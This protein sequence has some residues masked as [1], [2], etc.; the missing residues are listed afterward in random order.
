MSERPKVLVREEIA[1]AGV[2]L[3]REK[4]DVDVDSDERS[5]VDHRR[6]RR[7]RHPLRDQAHR[8]PDQRGDESEGDRARGRRRR[9]RRRGCGHPP[10]DRGRER[11]RVEHRLGRRAHG[12]PA[13]RARAEHPAGAQ[14]A[15]RQP[16][17]AVEVGR[18]RA[19]R[20][21]ARRARLRPDRPAGRAPRARDADA[22]R[23]LR[24]VR[25]RRAL[26]RGGRRAG[27]AR[28]RARPAPT[29]SR[30]TCR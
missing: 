7:D 14:R 20:E 16:L 11:A 1:E 28:R 5:R 6:L 10:R 8:R 3:L 21:D 4:F 2:D 15:G 13:V 26:P 24:P 9:Q 27:H 19:G 22:C 23:R 29:S 18:G 30:S 25:L 12:R 17:G